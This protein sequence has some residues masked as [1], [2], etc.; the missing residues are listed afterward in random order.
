MDDL[1]DMLPEIVRRL[2][3]ELDPA[4]IYLFGSWAEGQGREDSDLDLLVV[5]RR[6]DGPVRELARRGRKSLWG[7]AV[8]VD[9][10]VCTQDDMDKW[11]PVGCNLLHTVAK[12]GRLVY[13]AAG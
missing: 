7:L 10:V 1:P 8:P 9:L 6:G 2:A 4:G 11:A 12:K 13:G 3:A 5:V